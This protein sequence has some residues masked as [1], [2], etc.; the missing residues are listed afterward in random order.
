VV[1]TLIAPHRVSAARLAAARAAPDPRL[2]GLGSP[3]AAVL[4]GGDSRHGRVSPDEAARFVAALDRLAGEARLMITTSRRTPPALHDALREL[5]RRHGAF[6]WDGSGENPYIPMLALA[7]AVVATAD[8]ANMVGEAV[9]TGAP[10]LLFPLA[11]PYIRH[12]PFFAALGQYGAVHPFLGRLEGSPY[13]PLDFTP[14]IA[15]A[16]ASAFRR[17]RDPQ[18]GRTSP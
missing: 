6:L 10:V 3:R 4:V 9:A 14:A 2:A 11:D 1:T 8:S 18:A 7:D 16:V 5:A 15:E 12:R 17:Q 13:E